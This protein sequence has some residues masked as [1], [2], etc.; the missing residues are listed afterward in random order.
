MM[1][2][3]RPSYPINLR[4]L[5]TLLTLLLISSLACGDEPRGREPDPLILCNPECSSGQICLDGRCLNQGNTPDPD[6]PPLSMEGNPANGQSWTLLIYMIADNDLELAALL[7]LDEMMK[8]NTNPNLNIIVQIDRA[9]GYVSTIP[10]LP[11]IPDWT[12]TKRLRVQKDELLEYEDLGETNTGDPKHFEDFL[13][14]GLQNFPAD[15]TGIIL[16][17]HGG[18]WEGFGGDESFNKDMLSL[19]EIESAV[20]N[21]FA[22]TNTQRVAF[23][24]FDACFMGSYEVARLMRPYAHYMLASE[25]L[26]PGVGWEYQTLRHIAARPSISTE[27][28]LSLIIQEYKMSCDAYE[29]GADITLSAINL[30]QLHRLDAAVDALTQH[31]IQQ[32]ATTELLQARTQTYGFGDFPNQ[33]FNLYDI[34]DLAKQLSARGGDY[35]RLGQAILTALNSVVHDQITGPAAQLATGLTIYLPPNGLQVKQEYFTLNQGGA[36]PTLL[37]SFNQMAANTPQPTFTS[38][39]AITQVRDGQLIVAGQLDPQTSQYVT[40]TTLVIAAYDPNDNSVLLLASNPGVSDSTENLAAGV[41]SQQLLVAEQ[42]NYRSLLYLSTSFEGDY[43]AYTVPFVYFPDPNRQD[44]YTIAYYIQIYD[45]NQQRVLSER[46]YAMIGTN[47]GQFEPQQGS[48]FIPATIQV[49]E[50]GVQWTT[51]GDPFRADLPFTFSA[52]PAQNIKIYASLVI[53]DAL[54]R[55]SD[56]GALIDY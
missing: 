43:V 11:L 56:A 14:W 44:E 15:R 5:A 31:I 21:A 40:E 23:F 30:N 18:G 7:D 45:P 26:E 33:S 22:R 3:Q 49:S 12:T 53:Y 35:Q 36:W 6:A 48:V 1:T 24:G 28:L 16:W 29:V 9:D 39:E 47:I 51:I 38:P 25:E 20:K 46:Y 34:G 8:V 42:G 19:P 4:L 54:G 55:D 10:E 41:W 52:V 37:R 27:E 32:Q 50:A 17:N 2:P 13:V